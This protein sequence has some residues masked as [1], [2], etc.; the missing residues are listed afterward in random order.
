MRRTGEIRRDRNAICI[1]SVISMQSGSLDS[2]VARG[3]RALVQAAL[4]VLSV[5]ADA[6]G[7]KPP[8]HTDPRFARLLDFS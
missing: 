3:R 7:A 5:F 2:A 4:F 8:A 6:S 1:E